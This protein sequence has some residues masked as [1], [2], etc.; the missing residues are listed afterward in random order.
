MDNDQ[1]VSI[2]IEALVE[3]IKWSR[4]VKNDKDIEKELRKFAHYLVEYEGRIDDVEMEV[5]DIRDR[6]KG[7]D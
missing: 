3:R 5:N 7:Q 2:F 6:V 4:N 1:A